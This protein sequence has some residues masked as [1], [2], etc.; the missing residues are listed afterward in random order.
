MIQSTLE[1]YANVPLITHKKTIFL[2]YV[3]NESKDGFEVWGFKLVVV[4]F[5]YLDP[6]G[7]YYTL[8]LNMSSKYLDIEINRFRCVSN[9]ILSPFAPL[10]H[11]GL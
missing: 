11:R 9:M 3:P 10:L 6:F 7:N 2:L 8:K 5:Y 1:G 4:K